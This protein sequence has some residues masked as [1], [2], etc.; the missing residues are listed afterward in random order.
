MGYNLIIGEAKIDYNITDLEEPYID[1]YADIIKNK[2][3]P[4]YGE[5]TDYTSA[6][7]PSY[8]SWHNFTKF[9][10]LEDLF[11]GEERYDKL[12]KDHPG[13]SV[14]TKKH[15]QEIDEAYKNFKIKYPNSIA[16]YGDV[17][18]IFEEDKN[19]PE[20]NCWLCR[21]EWLKYWV[22]YVLENCERP[23]LINS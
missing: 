11:Y 21:L 8:T 19:N 18:D 5:P 20:E 12:L 23:V 4:A 6:R 15:K 17:K 10:K 1:I 3:A 13:C 14:I 16:T 22:D 2:N 7:W 9:V